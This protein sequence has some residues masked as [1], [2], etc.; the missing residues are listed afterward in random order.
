MFE[1]TLTAPQAGANPAPAAAPAEPRGA[2]LGV[3]LQ[4]LTPDLKTRLGVTA[5]KGALITDV[6]PNSAAAKADL[7]EGDV[8]TSVDGQPVESPRP[9]ARPS[10]SPASARSSP[11]RCGASD[12][13]LTSRHAEEALPTASPRPGASAA[14][15]AAAHRR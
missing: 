1:L 2:F 10:R 7:K 3:M 6:V 9:S 5:D 13:A 11:S 14:A 12:K 4:E 8:I 15:D